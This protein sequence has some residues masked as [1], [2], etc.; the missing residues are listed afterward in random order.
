MLWRFTTGATPADLFDNQLGLSL[1][2]HIP[3]PVEVRL[4]GVK[5]MI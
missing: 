2:P 3:L 1:V 4:S 5:T